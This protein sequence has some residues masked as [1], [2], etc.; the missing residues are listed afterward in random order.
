MHALKLT[1]T[2][3]RCISITRLIGLRALLRCRNGAVPALISQAF[4]DKRFS[5]AAVR[6]NGT[7]LHAT[8]P[9]L[10]FLKFRNAFLILYVRFYLHFLKFIP[11]YY[12]TSLFGIVLF[13]VSTK[14]TI[15]AKCKTEMDSVF[16]K[17][18][19]TDWK[20]HSRL[21]IYILVKTYF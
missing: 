5:K 20:K 16:K 13:H 19:P 8:V 12:Q 17:I 9:F 6:I 2:Y 3:L 15:F 4:K 14:T 7:L 1:L 10:G 21:C 11:I 18:K